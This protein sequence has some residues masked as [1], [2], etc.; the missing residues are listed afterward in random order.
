MFT[1][2]GGATAFGGGATLPAGAAAGRAAAEGA[3]AGRGA[4]GAAAGLASDFFGTSI[5]APHVGHF[6]RRPA[7]SSRA[8]KTFPHVH[9]NLMGIARL[10]RNPPRAATGDPTCRQPP[11]LT[12]ST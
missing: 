8:A 12:R 6:V 5:T 4:A 11:A 2:G 10:L 9:R 3:G 1:R 7:C